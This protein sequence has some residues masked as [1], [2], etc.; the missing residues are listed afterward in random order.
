MRAQRGKFIDAL[1]QFFSNGATQISRG[2]L[3]NEVSVYVANAREFAAHMIRLDALELTQ[4]RPRQ[5]NRASEQ[6]HLGRTFTEG[7]AQGAAISHTRFPPRRQNSTA[8]ARG[9]VSEVRCGLIGQA[10]GSRISFSSAASDPM[11]LPG[12]AR[13]HGVDFDVMMAAAEMADYRLSNEA[14]ARRI[15]RIRR[16]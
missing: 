11:R 12:S 2:A 1:F 16:D 3:K 9:R 6:S 8:G 14:M 4:S 5:G 7:K 13:H 10:T 15:Q